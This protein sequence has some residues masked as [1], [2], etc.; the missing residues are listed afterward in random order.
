MLAHGGSAFGMELSYDSTVQVLLVLHDSP[1]TLVILYWFDN[2]AASTYRK[3]LISALPFLVV[4]VL[5]CL[6]N[7]PHF[8][9]FAPRILIFRFLFILVFLVLLRLL[10]YSHYF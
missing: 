5:C 6:M 1:S 9:K 4:I 10:Y 7:H 8:K 2:N 3:A